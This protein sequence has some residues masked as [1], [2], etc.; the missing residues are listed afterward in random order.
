MNQFFAKTKPAGQVLA[1]MLIFVLFFILSSGIVAVMM[2]TMGM[3]DLMLSQTIVQLLTFGGTAIV[4]CKMFYGDPIKYFG[5][6]GKR[7]FGRFMVGAAVVLLSLIPVS[8]WLS[9]VNDGWHFPESLSALEKTLRDIGDNSMKLFEGYLM[10]PGVGSLFVNLLVMAVVPA[11]CE[12]LLFRGALQ[13]LLCRW[14]RNHHIGIWVTAAIFSLFHGEIFA[15]LPR[16]MLGAALGYVFYYS[17]SLWHNVLLHFLNNAMVVCLYFTAAR[18]FVDVQSVETFNTP[19]YF[20]LAGL[21]FALFFFRLFF[22]RA[23]EDPAT[24]VE[25]V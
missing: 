10:R 11:L 19:W 23:K 17:G 13:Q 3:P 12:E 14:F 24:E 22:L 1:L 16:F 15:F 21:A 7:H 20:A 4:F 8:D 6:D 9:V 5:L 25:K 18:G 2:M